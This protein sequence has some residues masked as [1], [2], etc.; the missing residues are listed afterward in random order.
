MRP[1]LETKGVLPKLVSKFNERVSDYRKKGLEKT[2]EAPKRSP[3][4]IN[5]SLGD[6]ISSAWKE[7]QGQRRSRGT[8]ASGASMS[9]SSQTSKEP[10]SST[11]LVREHPSSAREPT[12]ESGNCAIPSSLTQPSDNFENPRRYDD[13]EE[14]AMNNQ[15]YPLFADPRL[16]SHFL[17]PMGS[18]AGASW[19]QTEA[20]PNFGFDRMSHTQ[21]FDHT[22]YE[23]YH[24]LNP[25][26][27]SNE[28]TYMYPG[29][30]ETQQ[31]AVYGVRPGAYNPASA[32]STTP[33]NASQ[34]DS[35]PCQDYQRTQLASYLA[36]TS[37]QSYNASAPFDPTTSAAFTAS[38]NDVVEGDWNSV[39]ANGSQNQSYERMQHEQ[40]FQGYGGGQAPWDMMNSGY[41]SGGRYDDNTHRMMGYGQGQR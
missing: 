28:S 41:G 6:S 18:D 36:G 21:T 25:P 14:L 5:P 31:S 4:G 22:G 9:R 34:W 8:K 23:H 33:N 2:Y 13:P 16:R 7:H 32:P 11:F 37:T 1:E 30:R 12:I 19:T 26:S 10:V 15:F 29:P 3:P 17:R 24:C 39:F 27:S 38:Q 40:E 20:N 35:Y